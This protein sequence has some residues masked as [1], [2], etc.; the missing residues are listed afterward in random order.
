MKAYRKERMKLQRKQQ[1]NAKQPEEEE[2]EEA[3]VIEVQQ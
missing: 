1:A 2:K 3:K